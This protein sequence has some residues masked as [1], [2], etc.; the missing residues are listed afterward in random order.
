MSTVASEQTLEET[1]SKV[2]MALLSP[3]VSGELK[4]WIANVQQ[5]GATFAVDW[6]GYL[7]TLLHVQ[8]AEIGE[9]DPEL[10]PVV[11][12]MIETER[13]LLEDLARFHERLHELAKRAAD[14]KWQ[15]SKLAAEQQKVADAG[16]AL[17]L[18]VKKQRAAAATWLAE[19]VY[20]DRGSVD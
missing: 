8:Y 11:Q 5:A 3:V 13:R 19:A 1:L 16:L 9:N 18:E 15:E 7:N 10:L 20:R 12:K 2:E 6:T 17:I 4:S 14:V